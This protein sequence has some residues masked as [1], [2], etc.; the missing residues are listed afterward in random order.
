MEQ[1]TSIAVAI[2]NHPTPPKIDDRKFFLKKKLYL[3]KDNDVCKK[4]KYDHN[5]FNKNML[6]KILLRNQNIKEHKIS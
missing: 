2:R 4:N 5:T 1:T 3:I 6:G